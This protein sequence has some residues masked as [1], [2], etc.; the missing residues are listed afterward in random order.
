MYIF[1]CIDINKSYPPNNKQKY[2]G[3]W[4]YR[5]RFQSANKTYFACFPAWTC[6]S[7]HRIY[8]RKTQDKHAA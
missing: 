8:Q 2:H 3:L 6:R 1:D 4:L 7:A 5:K